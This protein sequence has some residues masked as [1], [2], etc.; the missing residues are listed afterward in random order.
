MKNYDPSYGPFP[1]HIENPQMELVHTGIPSGSGIAYANGFLYLVSAEGGGSLRIFGCVGDALTPLGS[2][3]GL[4][5][6]RQIKISAPSA[7][8]R[9]LAAVTARE[10]GLYLI[11]VTDPERPFIAC[12]YN[13]VE[14]AT[15]IAFGGQYLAIGCRNFGVEL[16]DI[17]I[18]ET[19][20]HICSIRAG[21]VQSM[22][23]FDGILYTGSWIERQVNVI[24]ISNVRSPKT[25]AVIPLEGRG[26]GL[27]VRD[28]ILYAAFGQHKRPATG[29]DPEEEGYACGN[30]FAIWDVT[31]PS[32]PKQLSATLFPHRYY[33]CNQDFWDVTV[34]GNFAVVS[35]TF[36]G[37]WIYDI[38][39]PAY[40]RLVDHAAIPT[41]LPMG[42]MMTL[43]D[44]TLNVRPLI[45]PF[46]YTKKS[47]APVTGVAAAEGRLYIAA[48]KQELLIARAEY[49]SPP[50]AAEVK[51]SETG[52][53]FYIHNPGSGD[54]SPTVVPTRGQTHAVLYYGG[55]LY[56]ASGMDGI[57]V[58]D[59]DL[60]HLAQIPVPGFA[61]DIREGG[62][63]VFVAAGREGVIIYRPCGTSLQE[64]GRLSLGKRACA[65]VVP[66][67][68]GRFLMLHT[69]DNHLTIVDVSDVKNP[70]VVMEEHYEPGLMYHRQLTPRGVADR[71]YGCFWNS[72]LTRWYDLG[73][74]VPVLTEY[75]QGNLS[76]LEGLTGLSE[77]YR[78][79]AVTRGGYVIA[80]IRDPRPYAEYPVH[81]IAGIRLYGKPVVK[82]GILYVSDR[83]TGE[84]TVL[85]IS[86]PC[87]P[88]LIFSYQFSGHPDLPCPIDGGVVIPLGHQGLARIEIENIAKGGYTL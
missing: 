79:L 74:D 85:D 8:G 86:D 51:L 46:D 68:N 1:P 16:I 38:T 75:A 83:L 50:K 20:R 39:D 70:R 73:G 43:N 14:F 82:D 30:G 4:G 21:E 25:L 22:C 13:S 53:D 9:V 40:P 60:R 34:S 37:V 52:E 10:C 69:D 15:G 57:G 48:L 31:N 36:N 88:K 33:V 7:R 28:G 17:A 64:V 35:H 11:D 3:T 63:Y 56:V 78:V 23:I 81:R 61:M 27:C 59:T 77:P 87:A 71:Y 84:V 42:E 55:L 2:I 12:H 19:P 44:F 49:F 54:A 5:N 80:D 24:D 76:F 6:L 32:E 29:R 72:N 67:A 47:Y 58:Y 62:G 41:G 26:D 65:Q 18:P 66:S 45:L